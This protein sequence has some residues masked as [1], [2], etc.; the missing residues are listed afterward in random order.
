MQAELP[1]GE[2]LTIKDALTPM[3]GDRKKWALANIST[4]ENIMHLYSIVSNIEMRHYSYL[5]L[6]TFW[7]MVKYLLFLEILRYHE[8]QFGQC[9]ESGQVG[10]KHKNLP[11]PDSH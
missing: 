6:P 2:G 9:K 4:A 3:A 5:G 11:Q 7:Y 10:M 1:L 8:W